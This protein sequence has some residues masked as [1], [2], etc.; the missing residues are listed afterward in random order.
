MGQSLLNAIKMIA[1]M[2]KINKELARLQ[3]KG[4]PVKNILEIIAN[5]QNT[6]TIVY[7][8]PEFQPCSESFSEKYAFVG[9]SIRPVK[10]S[11]KKEREKLIY[12]SMGTVNNDLLPVY[13][14]CINALKTTKYQVVM[15]VGNQINLN[16]IQCDAENISIFSSVDQIAVLRQADLF[17]THCGMNSVSEALYFGVPL[18]MLP[19]TPEQLG[20]AR[21]VEQLEAGILLKKCNVKNIAE[22]ASKL[23]S[24]DVYRNNAFTISDG[25]RSCS[26]AKGAANKIIDVCN[27]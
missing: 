12:I 19:Q 22:S 11:F 17:I 1:A 8:S 25:F 21:R 7:T 13:R 6:D 16:E 18:L 24:N 2:P 15:S 14:A 9:P 4:Y 23:L 5:D 20:V 3:K 26:G 10:E 27:S